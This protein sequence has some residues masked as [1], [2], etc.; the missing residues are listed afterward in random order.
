MCNNREN[1]IT[2]YAFIIIEN[3]QSLLE[4]SY[5]SLLRNDGLE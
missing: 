2:Y 5:I 4:K 1:Q 3:P